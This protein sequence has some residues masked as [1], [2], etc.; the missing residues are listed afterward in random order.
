MKC[1][2]WC[3]RWMERDWGLGQLSYRW[4]RHRS[5]DGVHGSYYTRLLQLGLYFTRLT[6]WF[7]LYKAYNLVH[8]IQDLW[9]IF[10]NDIR[11]SIFA[12]YM[13]VEIPFLNHFQYLIDFNK[14]RAI[15][16]YRGFWC[17]LNL[18]HFGYEKWLSNFGSFRS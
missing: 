4:L 12:C 18:W 17:N 8:T 5:G 15:A 13:W 6:T 10:L 2:E 9:F 16:C 14:D 7:V 1:S 11:S 3:W